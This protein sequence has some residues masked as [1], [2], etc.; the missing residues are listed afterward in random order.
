VVD[1][2][3]HVVHVFQQSADGAMTPL[4]TLGSRGDKGVG[5]FNFPTHAWVDSAGNLY[6]SD[7]MNYRVQIFD[8]DGRPTACFGTVGDGSGDF[9]KAKGVAA[10]ADGHVYVVDSLYDV[11]QIFDRSGRFLL[12]FGGSG[13]TGGLLWLPTGIFIDRE[14]RIYVADSGNSRVLVYRYVRQSP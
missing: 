3:A 9:S 8:P 12:A 7:S 13:R 4:R 2:G 14:D 1:T 6:V 10:D 11:V 5:T